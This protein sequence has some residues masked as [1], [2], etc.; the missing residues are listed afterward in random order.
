MPNRSTLSTE[1]SSGDLQDLPPSAKLVAKTLEYEGES[2]QSDLA[3]STRLP[4]RTVRHALT[5]LEANGLVTSR[6]S[7]MDAR[8]RIYSLDDT[9]E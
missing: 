6:M 8:Q 4:A 2:T 5:E 9:R 1:D 7:F 3:E